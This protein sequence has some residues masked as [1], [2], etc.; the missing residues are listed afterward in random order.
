L[1]KKNWLLSIVVVSEEKAAA[2]M[3]TY[4][5]TARTYIFLDL[6]NGRSPWA[7]LLLNSNGHNSIKNNG[8]YAN[9]RLCLAQT[10][11]SVSAA[12]SARLYIQV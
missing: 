1:P 5:R 4:L 8:D 12:P 11:E 7:E 6:A 10:L 3:P 2:F 9:G